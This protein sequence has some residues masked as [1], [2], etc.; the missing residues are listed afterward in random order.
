MKDISIFHLKIFIFTAVKNC[1]ISHRLV[2]VMLRGI[3]IHT[4]VTSHGAC[5]VTYHKHAL[6]K[7]CKKNPPENTYI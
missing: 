1:N 4:V 3:R 2:F 5:K 6:S 7:N